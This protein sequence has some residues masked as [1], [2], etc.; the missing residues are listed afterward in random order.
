[1]TEKLLSKI[2]YALSICFGKQEAK[3]IFNELLNQIK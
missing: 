2:F 1:M 3:N